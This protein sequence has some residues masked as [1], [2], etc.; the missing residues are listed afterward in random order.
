M[1]L[2]PFWDVDASVAEV[3]RTAAKGAKAI[4]F[5]EAPHRLGLPS[6]HSDHWDPFLAAAQDADMPLCMH[7]GSGGA[8]DVAPDANF[9]VAIA[10]FGMNSQFATVDL[11]FSPVFHKFP[12]LQGG[13]V[14]GRHRLDP[15]RASSGST[16]CGSGTAGTR[17][18]TPTCGRRTCSATTSSAA[19]SP[20]RPASRCATSSASSN[21]MFEGDYPHSDSNYPASRKKLDE[22]L[23]DVPDDEARAIAED[24][25]RRV[26]NFPRA[27]APALRRLATVADHLNFVLLGLGNGAVFAALAV[28][29][30]VT[31]RSSGVLNF[32]TGAHV[33]RTRPTP[34]RSSGGASC[35]SRCRGCRARSTSAARCA[36][37]PA[38]RP[39]AR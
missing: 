10:L 11:L 17:A 21:L 31:Y 35:S 8:P 30:V 22:V 2:V 20:T 33:A 4:T 32:A 9:A 23:R 39:H 37:W 5:T 7:F 15:L 16:T 13:A 24:N 34:T 29:L 1:V 28:A 3:E 36:F 12:R 26:F 6:F 18:S 38:L 14:R 25:A 19:S 27:A